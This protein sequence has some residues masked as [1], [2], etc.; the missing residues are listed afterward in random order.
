MLS[1]CIVF[2]DGVDPPS[3]LAK[4]ALSLIAVLP[5]AVVFALY[6][7]YFDTE[8]WKLPVKIGTLLLTAFGAVVNC[9]DALARDGVESFDP[10]VRPLSVLLF[11]AALLLFAV[12]LFAFFGVLLV[13][14]PINKGDTGRFRRLSLL[15]LFAF[16]TPPWLRCRCCRRV[17]DRDQTGSDAAE[18]DVQLTSNPLISRNG[19]MVAKRLTSASGRSFAAAVLA[20][21]RA[22]IRQGRSSAERAASQRRMEFGPQTTARRSS[23]SARRNSRV[24]VRSVELASGRAFGG[25]GAHV[26]AI[27]LNNAISSLHALQVFNPALR[28]GPRRSKKR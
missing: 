1:V 28:G 24:Q 10:L 21:L 8:R 22:S 17:L 4:L 14:V 9:F 2:L 6:K 13:P 3:V 15:S 19:A 11:I 16:T 26:P 5:Y 25:A 20:P 18:S 23:I 12:L 27:S 7:P